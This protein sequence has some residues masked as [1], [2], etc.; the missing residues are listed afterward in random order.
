M[1]ETV[2]LYKCDGCSKVITDPKGGIV[3]HGNIYVADPTTKGGLV[4]NNFPGSLDEEGVK[5]FL[6]NISTLVEESVYCTP[7]FLKAV[8]P[9]LKLTR[10]EGLFD[11]P[12]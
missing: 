11:R 10:G 8:F 12:L 1:S 5:P 6:S 2:E 7:C 4:G 9:D 3:I